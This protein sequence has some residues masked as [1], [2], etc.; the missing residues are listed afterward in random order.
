[1]RESRSARI[2]VTVRFSSALLLDDKEV[3]ISEGAIVDGARESELV[4]L[5]VFVNDFLILGKVLLPD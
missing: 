3:L 4:E 2:R 5:A 1:L